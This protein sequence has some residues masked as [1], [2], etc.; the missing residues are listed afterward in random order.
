MKGNIRENEFMQ[1]KVEQNYTREK[2]QAR[3]YFQVHP[4]R[5]GQV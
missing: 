5:E 1:W 2:K 3:F 4:Y